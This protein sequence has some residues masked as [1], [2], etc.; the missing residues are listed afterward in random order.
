MMAV[1]RA[2]LSCPV[3]PVSTALPQD[4]SRSPKP[5]NSTPSS[6][7]V[8][9]PAPLPTLRMLPSSSGGC[10]A[11]RRRCRVAGVMAS[12]EAVLDLQPKAVSQCSPGREMCRRAMFAS[13]RRF[14]KQ[15]Q[16]SCSC[17]A[18]QAVL[19][20]V[21]DPSKHA[22]HAHHADSS[23]H[24]CAGAPL[25]FSPISF[26]PSPL[27]SI[28]PPFHTQ[29]LQPLTPLTSCPAVCAAAAGPLRW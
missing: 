3:T 15:A 5:W 16:D 14:E 26:L 11:S 12:S 18:R 1:V 17:K 21:K 22:H 20:D 13:K 2:A 19:A 4:R 9:A 25:L 27:G 23:Q 6:G 29:L 8:P 7:R 10:C 24:Q 28:P